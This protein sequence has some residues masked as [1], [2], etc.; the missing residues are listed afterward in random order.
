MCVSITVMVIVVVMAA[1]AVAE[2]SAAAAVV[3]Y[4]SRG[5]ILHAKYLILQLTSHVTHDRWGL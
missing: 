2:V 5:K 1:V 3:G 4:W